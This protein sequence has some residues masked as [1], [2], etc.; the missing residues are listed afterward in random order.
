MRLK[1]EDALEFGFRR[2]ELCLIEIG[3]RQREMRG[4]KVGSEAMERPA[5]LSMEL[6]TRPRRKGRP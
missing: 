3:L 6:V 5:W 1:F 4:D 2:S